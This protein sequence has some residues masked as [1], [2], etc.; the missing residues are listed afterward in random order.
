MNKKHKIIGIIGG[1]GPEA[2]VLFQSKINAAARKIIKTKQDIDYPSIIHLSFPSLIADRSEYLLGISEENPAFAVARIAKHI[3]EYA[4]T[5]KEKVLL[6]IPCGTFHAEP[7]WDIFMELVAPLK[8]LEVVHLIDEA[9]AVISRTMPSKTI[10][11][12]LST[13]G[14]S[15]E[16]VFHKRL[17]PLGYHIHDLTPQQLKDIHKAIYDHDFGLKALS[18]GS[19]KSCHLIESVVKLLKE[20]GV[21]RIILGSTELSLAYASI[22]DELYIDP[23]TLLADKLVHMSME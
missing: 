19:D 4:Q 1:M 14:T 7:I 12:I 10:F 21:E 2:G 22:T 20:Q 17:S 6:A 3:D 8:N 5:E 9:V 11:S 16:R 23:L 15:Q 13:L 18:R